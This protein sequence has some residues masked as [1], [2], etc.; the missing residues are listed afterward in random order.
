VPVVPG[1]EVGQNCHNGETG[2][3]IIIS[4]RDT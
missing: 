1:G 2:W 3:E 4:I